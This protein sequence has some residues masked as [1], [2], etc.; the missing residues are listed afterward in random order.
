MTLDMHTWVIGDIILIDN[1]MTEDKMSWHEIKT[2]T[3]NVYYSVEI[4]FPEAIFVAASVPRMYLFSN[5]YY[6]SR[7]V[8]NEMDIP[9]VPYSNLIRDKAN[10]DVLCSGIWQALGIVIGDEEL[11]KTIHIYDLT[12]ESYM[13]YATQYIDKC[14]IE[15]YKTAVDK[16]KDKLRNIA[17]RIVKKPQA[18]NSM[19]QNL[20][21]WAK[22]YNTNI[23]ALEDPKLEYPE[24]IEW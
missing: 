22:E 20:K 23:Y 24:E 14:N 16:R 8:P 17:K 2:P 10:L 12:R 6:G 5:R 15:L 18:Y 13:N 4:L 1:N 21:Y 7:A 11:E 9:P 19:E 3:E